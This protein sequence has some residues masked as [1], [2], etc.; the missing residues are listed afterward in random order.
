MKNVIIAVTVLSLSI[1]AFVLIISYEPKEEEYIPT[2]YEDQPYTPEFE[3][4]IV[5]TTADFWDRVAGL[6]K[7]EESSAE[8]ITVTDENGNPVTDEEGNEVTEPFIQGPQEFP[9]SPDTTEAP[10]SLPDDVQSHVSE[11]E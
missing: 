5:T 2:T 3:L 8:Y 7:T 11:S 6:K 9:E 1:I 4:Q 10:K